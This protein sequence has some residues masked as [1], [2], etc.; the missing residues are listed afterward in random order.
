MVNNNNIQITHEQSLGLQGWQKAERITYGAHSFTVHP[1]KQETLWFRTAGLSLWQ[2][3]IEDAD[4]KEI[5]AAAS[6]ETYT[7]IL[8]R[9]RVEP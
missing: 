4:G 6:T 9:K 3:R 5:E 8:H 7:V 2:Y 1:I